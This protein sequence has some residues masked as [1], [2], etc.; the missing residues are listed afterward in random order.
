[1]SKPENLVLFSYRVYNCTNIKNHQSESKIPID[2]SFY[3]ESKTIF[4]KK[5]KQ[6]MT[7]Y[8][9]VKLASMIL[10]IR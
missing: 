1:M 4:K 8:K 5:K 3:F 7:F 2:F 9:H 6:L 10:K